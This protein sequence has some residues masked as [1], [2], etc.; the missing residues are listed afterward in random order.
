MLNCVSVVKLK[1]FISYLTNVMNLSTYM[2][3]N[4]IFSLGLMLIQIMLF[5]F[6]FLINNGE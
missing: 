4:E 2:R 5:F 6:G 1:I 3:Q